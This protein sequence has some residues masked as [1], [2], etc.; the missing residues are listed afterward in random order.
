MGNVWAKPFPTG[1]RHQSE[2]GGFW[3]FIADEWVTGW[4][5]PPL[6]AIAADFTDIGDRGKF[7]RY[8]RSRPWVGAG[9]GRRLTAHRYP[10]QICPPYAI[11]I[12]PNRAGFGGSLRVDG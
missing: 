6:R 3:G 7:H 11:A 5:N 1:D 9:S 10:T 4:L 12:N 2:P 8:W